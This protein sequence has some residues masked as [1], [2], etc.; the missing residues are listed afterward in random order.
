MFRLG[1]MNNLLEASLSPVAGCD[2][3][4]TLQRGCPDMFRECKVNGFTVTGLVR[5]GAVACTSA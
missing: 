1:L 3:Q 4:S 5:I 2:A